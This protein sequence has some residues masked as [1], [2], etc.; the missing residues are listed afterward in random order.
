MEKQKVKGDWTTLLSNTVKQIK[1]MR[2]KLSGLV[3]SGGRQ[4]YFSDL[5][6]E[7]KTVAKNKSKV[8]TSNDEC[9]VKSKNELDYEKYLEIHKKADT[10]GMVLG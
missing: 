9:D 8:K 10:E 1:A 4:I 3:L 6:S 5:E 2:R 7:T